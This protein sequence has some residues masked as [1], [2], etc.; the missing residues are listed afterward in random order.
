MSNLHLFMEIV[1]NSID[2]GNPIIVIYLDLKKGF[3]RVPH[4]RH[5]IT[6]SMW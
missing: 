1:G 3:D 4:N 2:D 5:I 6:M